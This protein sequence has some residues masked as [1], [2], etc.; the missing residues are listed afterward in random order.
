MRRANGAG[1]SGAGAMEGGAM[2]KM[3]RAVRWCAAACAAI[4]L[5]A[6]A[7]MSTEAAQVEPACETYDMDIIE[8]CPRCAGEAHFIQYE[9]WITPPEGD[10]FTSETG[11]SWWNITGDV[12]D[13]EGDEQVAAVSVSDP[14]IVE[15]YVAT[16]NDIPT[17]VVR[18]KS[19]GSATVTVTST[20]DNTADI[21]F[22]V[23]DLSNDT[24]ALDNYGNHYRRVADVKVTFPE[25]GRV[26]DLANLTPEGVQGF[27]RF[28]AVNITDVDG[29]S[30]TLTGSFEVIS[31]DPS[32]VKPAADG[33]MAF[34]V[35]KP[36]TATL[37]VR[38]ADRLTDQVHE[39]SVT[40]T[41]IDSSE[42][43]TTDPEPGEGGAQEEDPIVI[44]SDGSSSIPGASITVAG[45]SE[46]MQELKQPGVNLVI[47]EITGTGDAPTQVAGALGVYEIELRA[48]DGSVL[49]VDGADGVTLTVKIPLTNAMR[50]ADPSTLAVY[51]VADDGTLTAKETWVEGDFLCFKTTHLSTYLVRS[52]S[53]VQPQQPD[54]PAA[55]ADGDE[56]LAETGD[57]SLAVIVAAAGA[58]AAAL[59]GGCALN[60]KRS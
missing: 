30:W 43:S 52:V 14:E 35:L 22:T 39:A 57:P 18:A 6:A 34:Q 56:E 51:Y 25:E 23:H 21:T 29:G 9:N 8:H 42:G 37:T 55:D 2:G 27:D 45:N 33:T 11:I 5:A 47:N 26:Y 32:V 1:G 3:T 53:S 58:A 7:P 54:A 15:A 38:I 46:K 31:S 28:L 48:G 10:Y 44:V 4:V 59:A 16:I 19:A 41:V 24:T 36:G 40:V 50:A 60:R 12:A 20:K 49:S 13:A 17:A